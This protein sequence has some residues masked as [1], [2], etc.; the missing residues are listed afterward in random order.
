MDINELKD[1]MLA[2][3]EEQFDPRGTPIAPRWEGG[4]ITL[5]PSNDTQPKEV[6][7]EIF[8]KKLLTVR[9]SLRILEQKIASH[10][11]IPQTD[12]INFQT[13]IT[14]AYG[15]LTTFNILF[16]DDKHKFVG[17]G[18]KDKEE[19]SKSQMTLGEARKKLGLN[20]Y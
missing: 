13:Y 19:L 15:T 11:Q 5:T 12:K 16:K 20:E 10:P 4:T 2:L 6:P 18:G 3:I 7:I 17:S 14:K 9:D 8:F 1:F